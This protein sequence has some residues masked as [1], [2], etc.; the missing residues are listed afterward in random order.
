MVDADGNHVNLGF[1]GDVL[2]VN[3]NWDDNVNSN[4]GLVSAR[5]STLC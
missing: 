1:N 5:Q 3:D 4:L 2:N